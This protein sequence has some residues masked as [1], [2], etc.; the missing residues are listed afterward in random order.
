LSKFGKL[1]KS[2]FGG[3][4]NALGARINDETGMMQFG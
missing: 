2:V 4:K 3:P 1:G